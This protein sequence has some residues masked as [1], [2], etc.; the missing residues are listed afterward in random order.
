MSDGP[1][2]KKAKSLTK[3]QLLFE[4][5]GLSATPL[6]LDVIRIIADYATP[7]L[8]QRRLITSFPFP[9]TV[10]SIAKTKIFTFNWVGYWTRDL[11]TGKRA[12]IQ[13][14]SAVD[15]H[16]IFVIDCPVVEFVIDSKSY[17]V[18]EDW[19]ICE[20]HLS[21]DILLE[22]PVS[23]TNQF[24]CYVVQEQFLVRADRRQCE[25]WEIEIC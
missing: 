23:L 14:L 1:S 15:A 2:K 17:E 9:E 5:Y 13:G 12:P 7:V 25:I 3:N 6:C 8:I 16:S 18:K 20:N 11:A 22:T 4:H 19:A 21:P 24:S 10:I